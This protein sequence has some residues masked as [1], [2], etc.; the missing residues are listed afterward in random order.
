M[1]TE[2]Q[3]PMSF[4]ESKQGFYLTNEIILYVNIRNYKWWTKKSMTVTKTRSVEEK[5]LEIKKIQKAINLL[6]K[7]FGAIKIKKLILDLNVNSTIIEL[8]AS[9]Q[10]IEKE[11]IK[12]LCLDNFVE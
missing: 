4:L 6:K 7:S 11:F 5:L 9:S 12:A 2:N 10:W 3:P 8:L 1:G